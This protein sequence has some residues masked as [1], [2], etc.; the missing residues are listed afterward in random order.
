MTFTAEADKVLGKSVVVSE[1]LL[2]SDYVLAVHEDPEDEE[3]TVYYPVPAIRTFAAAEDG[4]REICPGEDGSACITDTVIIENI[5]PGTG[6]TV[7]GI[8]VDKE[9][10]KPLTDDEGNFLEAYAEAVIKSLKDSVEVV[11][12]ADYA[13][14]FA[15][16]DIVVFEKLCLTGTDKVLALHEDT[17]DEAQTVHVQLPPEVPDTGDTAEPLLHAGAFLAALLCAAALMLFRRRSE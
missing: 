13:G 2:I 10:G 14:L 6:V 3:Q 17:N 11:F 12:N 16:R 9:T 8:L 5:R 7:R 4:G 15:G 1:T